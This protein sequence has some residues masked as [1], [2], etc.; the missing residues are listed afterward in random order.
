MKITVH[1]M[2]SDDDGGTGCSAWPTET[3]AEDALLEQIGES[4]EE[5]EHWRNRREDAGQDDDFWTFVDQHKRDPSMDTYNIDENTVD[6]DLCAQPLPDSHDARVAEAMEC[7][8]RARQLLEVPAPVPVDLIA[9][10]RELV[11][12]FGGNVPD[13]LTEEVAMLELALQP[14]A[15]QPLPVPPAAPS[16]EELFQ[17]WSMAD[18]VEAQ[19]H[20]WELSQCG[21]GHIAIIVNDETPYAFGGGVGDERNINA[22]THVRYFGSAAGNQSEHADLKRRDPDRAA[23]HE[24]CARAMRIEAETAAARDASDHE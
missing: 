6:F 22:W 21:D 12:A 13:W 16:D 17:G 9:A 4:R 23:Y 19:R 11:A 8:S 1:M 10:S 5:F 20:G 14:F 15:D 18:Q 7:L 2:A 24:L 3:G